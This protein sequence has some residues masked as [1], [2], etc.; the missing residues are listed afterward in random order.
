MGKEQVSEL[1]KHGWYLSVP[2]GVS[3][4]P[5]IRNGKDIVEIRKPD[6]ELKRY[7]LVMYTRGP[8]EQ[9]VIHRVLRDQRRKKG[10]FIICGD[11]CWR[12]E[13]IKPERIHGIVTKFCRNGKWHTVDEKPYLLYV[14][15]WCDFYHIRAGILWTKAMAR[16]ALGKIRRTVTGT[17]RK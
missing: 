5:M 3:M 9:G 6:R 16:R 8:N 2:R 4:Y 1:E 14:H 13:Y 12:L 17:K 15:L 11:N 7:D 10:V